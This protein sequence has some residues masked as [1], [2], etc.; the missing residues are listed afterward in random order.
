[1]SR[2][3]PIVLVVVLTV[4]ALVDCAMTPRTA[5]RGLRKAWWLPVVLLVPVVGPVL[6]LALGR[7]RG[8][9]P[10]SRPAS[11]PIAPDD[12]DEFLRQMDRIDEEH[13]RMLEQWER[14]LRR[15]ERD[16][17]DGEGHPGPDEPPT[18]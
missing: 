11:R 16:M 7:P 4:F 13:R 10:G 12:D 6:W 2:A 18:R 14:D 15:R 1:M 3:L 17:H 8:Q 9:R 5:T